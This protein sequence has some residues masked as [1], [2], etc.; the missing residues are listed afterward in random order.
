[1]EG[2]LYYMSKFILEVCVDSVESAI[3]AKECGAHRIELCSNLIVGGTTPSPK[4]FEEV[5]RNCGLKTHIL[6]RPRFGDFCY[7][8]YEFD[9]M[10]EEVKMFRELGAD[11]VVVG[12]LNPDGTLNQLQMEKLVVE[13][14]KMPV[15]LHRAFD[16]CVD[17]VQTLEQAVKLKIHTILTSG[18]NHNCLKGAK[19]IYELYKAANGKIDIM[20]GGGVNAEVIKKIYLRTGITSYHMSGKKVIESRMTYRKENVNM[21]LNG[22]NEYEIYRADEEQ[23]KRAVEIIDKLK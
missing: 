6:I 20:V 23:I 3:V 11:G 10:K 18:Q 22:L 17:P 8:D 15:T 19:V 16:M 7:T 14:G 9:V 5:K 1:M 13:A 2:V 4:L 21:G 12:V